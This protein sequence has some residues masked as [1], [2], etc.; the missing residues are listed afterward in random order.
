M[1]KRSN[2]THQV[3]PDLSGQPTR[4]INRLPAYAPAAG[5]LR[6]ASVKIGLLGKT[7]SSYSAGSSEESSDDPGGHLK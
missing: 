3:S 7:A 4:F 1:H 5:N 6:E 2:A